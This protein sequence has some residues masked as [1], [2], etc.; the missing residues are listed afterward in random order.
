MQAHRLRDRVDQDRIRHRERDDVREVQVD[1]VGIPHYRLVLCL[2]DLNQDHED[3]A[4]QEEQRC[5][6]VPYPSCPGC[7]LDLGVRGLEVVREGAVRVVIEGAALL[8]AAEHLGNG[9]RRD[10]PSGV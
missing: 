5:D 3:H 1:E 2:A 7:S 9:S 6:Q 4:D 10:R 8:L